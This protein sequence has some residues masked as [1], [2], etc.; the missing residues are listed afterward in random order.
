MSEMTPSLFSAVVAAPFGRMG[1]RLE[2]GDLRELVYLPAAYELR[3]PRDV[4]SREIAAQLKAY[5]KQP[6]FAFSLPIPRRRHRASA[7]SMAAD[8]RHTMRRSAD[9]CAGRAPN[10]LRAARGRAG[11]RCELVPIDHSVPS[12]HCRKW[13]WW[14]CAP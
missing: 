4:L 7:Q 14:L 10:R 6:D 2:A 9:L 13:Y 12:G 8:I 11:L 3:T 1:I 5:F